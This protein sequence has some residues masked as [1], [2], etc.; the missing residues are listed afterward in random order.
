MT[1][2]RRIRRAPETA[3]GPSRELSPWVLSVLL[4]VKNASS[5]SLILTVIP[6]TFASFTL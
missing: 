2:R 3:H 4:P 1:Y 6:H 5:T